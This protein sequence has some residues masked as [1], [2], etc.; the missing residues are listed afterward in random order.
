MPRRPRCESGAWSI[1][2]F[3]MEWVASCS[4][5]LQTRQ[6]AARG[7]RCWGK[8]HA[9]KSASW[10]CGL[11]ALPRPFHNRQDMTVVVSGLDVSSLDS[12]DFESLQQKSFPSR[13][14]HALQHPG[15]LTR[16]YSHQHTSVC[17]ICHSSHSANS[18]S[19]SSWK[20]KGGAVLCNQYIFASCTND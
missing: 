17:D 1:N 19:L 10:V 7:L 20:G 5:A 14:H 8:C 3:T 9:V 4:E 18:W 12:R 11:G 2:S 16:P 13:T 15:V 6:C